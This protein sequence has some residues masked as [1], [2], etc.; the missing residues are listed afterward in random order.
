MQLAPDRGRSPKDLADIEGDVHVRLL[1]AACLLT[2]N[3]CHWPDEAL[4]VWVQQ[5]SLLLVLFQLQQFRSKTEVS[6]ACC[7][8]MSPI[9][10][11]NMAIALVQDMC[12]GLQ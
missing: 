3:C 5:L 11:C 6:I 2:Q 10:A 9:T 1:L 7:M 8:H 4:H 12:H